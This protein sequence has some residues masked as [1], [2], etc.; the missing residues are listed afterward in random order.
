MPGRGPAPKDPSRRARRNVDTTPTT[1]L[2]FQSC[3]APQLPDTID[4]HPQTR[5]WW[6]TWSSSPMA[7]IMGP[8]DWDFLLDTAL[9]HNALW[10]NGHWTVA[11]E[12]RLRVS[13]FGA[14]PED[15]LRLRIQWADADEK[16]AARPQAVSVPHRER[17][18]K[19]RVVPTPEEGA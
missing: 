9:M 13:K 7:E 1:T 14:T 15:R 3:N 2:P 4:W 16:D 8:T 11:A 17:Y 18:A 5:R 6:E 10:S 12:L 19:L